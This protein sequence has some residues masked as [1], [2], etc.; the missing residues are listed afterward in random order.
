MKALLINGSRSITAN[1]RLAAQGFLNQQGWG[2]PSL[3][4][5]F[6]SFSTNA[7][8]SL[9]EKHWRLRYVDQTATNA[10]A[11]GQSKTWNVTLTTN[12]SGFPLRVTLVWTDPPGNPNVGVKLVNDLDL[13]VTNLDSG[14][15]FYGNNISPGNYLT[16]PIFPAQGV[17]AAVDS[18]NNVENVFVGSPFEFGRNYSIT[19]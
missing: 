17:G 6:P 14:A 12:A 16:E 11:T 18:V 15:V 13:V 4:A 8:S 19:V 10:L 2:L 9:D 1:Y 3:P 5:V 7:H